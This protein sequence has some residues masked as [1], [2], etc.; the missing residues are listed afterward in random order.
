MTQRIFDPLM[1]AAIDVS[2]VRGASLNGSRQVV[3][4]MTYPDRVK[5]VVKYPIVSSDDEFMQ[6]LLSAFVLLLQPT[7]SRRWTGPT[8][9]TTTW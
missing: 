1:K 3:S 4:P 9:G 6:V 2:G 5:Q 7:F 8:S